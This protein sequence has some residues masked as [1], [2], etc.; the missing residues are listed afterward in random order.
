MD[1][2]QNHQSWLTNKFIEREEHKCIQTYLESGLEKKHIRN[3]CFER[4]ATSGYT[5]RG[6]Y[7]RP[8]EYRAFILITRLSQFMARGRLPF[9]PVYHHAQQHAKYAV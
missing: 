5:S 7:N 3:I 9:V 1:K 2:F 6:N 8:C 4:G